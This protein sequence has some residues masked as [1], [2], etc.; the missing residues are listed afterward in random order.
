MR[1]KPRS[2]LFTPTGTKGG[3]KSDSLLPTRITRTI[4]HGWCAD[5]GDS[6]ATPD[7]QLEDTWTNSVTCHRNAAA[8]WTGETGFFERGCTEIRPVHS[9]DYPL[10]FTDR[11]EPSGA[12]AAVASRILMKVFYGGS[13]C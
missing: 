10:D 5:G 9:S 3:P 8:K 7:G 1:D 11:K 6:S 4:F 13:L 12:L 2:A